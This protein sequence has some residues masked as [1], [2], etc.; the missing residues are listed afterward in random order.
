MATGDESPAVPHA[1]VSGAPPP[2]APAVAGGTTVPGPLA[3]FA[4]PP[5]PIVGGAPA[6]ITSA[7]VARQ[8]VS[9][10]LSPHQR[11][12]DLAFTRAA[13]LNMV[14]MPQ[15]AVQQLRLPLII[16]FAHTESAPRN[17]TY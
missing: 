13:A 7:A 16:M 10:S 15:D 5:A 9:S 1:P 11:I 17:R 12:M 8:S 14:P 3:A 6:I 4:A 2:T